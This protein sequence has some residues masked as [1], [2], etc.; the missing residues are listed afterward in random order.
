MLE[1]QAALTYPIS[2]KY[3]LDCVIPSH[4]FLCVLT[5]YGKARIERQSSVMTGLDLGRGGPSSGAQ[6]TGCNGR[7]WGFTP[8]VG[9]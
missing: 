3:Q 1:Y 4:R 7:I 2:V 6:C 5:M 8:T 9:D